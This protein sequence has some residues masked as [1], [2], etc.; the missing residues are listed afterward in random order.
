MTDERDRDKYRDDDDMRDPLPPDERVGT[1]PDT[2]HEAR[3][4][5]RENVGN[6]ARDTAADRERLQGSE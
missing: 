4:D 6:T 1:K 3:G 2:K 5:A